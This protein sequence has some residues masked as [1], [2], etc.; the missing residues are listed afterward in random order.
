MTIVATGNSGGGLGDFGVFYGQAVF[1]VY[2]DMA[3]AKGNR[4]PAWTLQFAAQ[5]ASASQGML[6]PPLPLNKEL[7][8]LPPEIASRY[9]GRM[10]VVFA[11]LDA[12]GKLQKMRVLQ[13]P[14]IGLNQALLDALA[15]WSFHPAYLGADPVAV[16]A[17]VG[18]PIWVVQD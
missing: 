2:I 4:V 7:P 9:L 14:N 15:K 3:D 5:A 17:L 16:R 8:D 6:I 18:I 13:S 11:V 12:D 10:A 1:T